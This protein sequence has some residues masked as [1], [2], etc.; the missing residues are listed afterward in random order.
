MSVKGRRRLLRISSD[1]EFQRTV[2]FLVYHAPEGSQTIDNSEEYERIRRC[3]Q[4]GRD[5]YEGRH[6]Y[7]GLGVRRRDISN[8][9][10]MLEY[11]APE[12]SQ[13]IDNSEE[14]ERIRRCVQEGRDPYEGRHTYAGL[15]VRRKHPSKPPLKIRRPT[16]ADPTDSSDSGRRAVSRKR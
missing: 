2:P 15:G 6:T 14:Y 16:A 7:A 4:E 10:P 12:G 11:H 1:E 9:P 8:P 5:P 3:V 13:T